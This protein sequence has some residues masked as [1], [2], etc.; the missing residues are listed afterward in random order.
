MMNN[1]SR[2]IKYGSIVSYILI[3]I[4]IVLG[5]I[6][7]PWILKT[8]GSSDYGLYTLASS[9]IALFLLDFGMSAAVTR[10]LSNYRAQNDQKSI[11]SFIGLTIK[12]YATICSAIAIILVI[13]FLNIDKIY[14]NLADN[15]LASFKTVF[16]I[17]AFFVVVCFPVN[18][19]NGI[20]NAFE[21]Y[22]W[23]KGSDILNKV[24][25][26]IVT[27]VALLIGGG[28]YALVF[29]NGLF[30]LVTFIIKIIIIR[31]TTP[32]K[33]SFNRNDKV[34]I[35]DIFSF[36]VWS[37]V[38]SLSQQMIFNLIPTV[39]AMVTNT[40]A[41]TLY[42]FANVIEGYVYTITQAINGMFMPSVS[43]IIV[44]DK[45]A[46][47]VLPLMI[48]VGRI[49]QSVISLLLV[50]LIVL[51]QEFVHLWVGDDYAILYYC[52]ILVCFPYF[53][54]AAQQIGNTSVV[55]LNKIKLSAI[56][57]LFTGLINLIGAY[58]IADKF[59]VIGVCSLIGLISIIR[60]IC[61][62][63]VYL[64]VLK[65]D[66]WKFYKGCQLKMLPSFLI[67]LVVS[68]LFV[69]FLPLTAD[70][71]LGWGFF[72]VKGISVTIFYVVVMWFMGWNEYEKSLIKS[73]LPHRIKNA[74]KAKE[75]KD[76]E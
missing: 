56:I 22:I 55:V 38:S 7:T 42:G 23:L 30:N 24:G 47:K 10:F 51:G 9:L 27:I 13:V 62:N 59:G 32:L 36:S 70:G 71:F 16:I 40:L 4:N 50:G 72:A 25:T 57:N 75:S 54:S 76:Y 3:V 61:Y 28:I 65:I 2:Q 1:Q 68:Y 17:T 43:R 73:F 8:V 69:R 26:V 60:V 45:D 29:I 34:G 44:N 39:L 31:Y 52:I 33:V 46:S 53:F 63:I 37:T 19:C 14:S 67:S 64:N 6:Y 11:N 5:L 66:I 35:K 74:N 49:N 12:F 21:Q 15:E 48:K 20:L 58:F 18:V 41:I